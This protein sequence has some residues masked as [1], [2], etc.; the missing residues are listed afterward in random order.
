M[1]LCYFNGVNTGSYSGFKNLETRPNA[2][3]NLGNGEGF[4]NLEVLEMVEKVSDK[5]INWEFGPRRP[6]DPAVL[7]AS[8]ELAQKELGWKPKYA[9][10][11]SIV[12]SA[13][14][15]HE[16]H[17]LGYGRNVEF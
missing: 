3:Y 5:K 17:P 16:A 9:D 2:K 14:E 15:W 7:I 13:W 11:E 8:S 1:I 6:G 10:L 4:S 12:K